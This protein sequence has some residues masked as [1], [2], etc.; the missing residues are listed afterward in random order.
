MQ[1]HAKTCK[2][3]K[4]YTKACRS[5]KK[6]SKTMKAYANYATV[7]MS[8]KSYTKKVKVG[9]GKEEKNIAKLPGKYWKSSQKVFGKYHTLS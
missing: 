8:I 3:M 6:I 4:G 1:N 5:I 9:K 2:I 7:C